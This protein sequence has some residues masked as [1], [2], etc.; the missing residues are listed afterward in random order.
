M[1][2]RLLI[3][4]LAA[5]VVV[6]AL[7]GFL[8]G[9][10][11]PSATS[12]MDMASASPPAAVTADRVTAPGD[13]EIDPRRQQLI[14]VRTAPVKRQALTAT[15][16]TTGTV[17]ADETRQAD[18]NVRLDG[19]IRELFVNYTGQPVRRGERLFTLYS[20]ELLASTGELL[21][22][23]RNREQ[24][25]NAAV[26]D[27]AGYAGQ[28][29]DAARRR[30]AVW[31]LSPEQIAAIE[32]GGRAVDTL[33]ITAPISGIVTEKQAVAGMR[34][35]AGQTLYRIGDLSS[36]WIEADVYE[37]DMAQVRIGQ[38]ATVSLAAYPDRRWT[39][40]AIYIM[41][42]VNEQTRTG[43]VR[44]QFANPAGILKP[45]T[46][47]NVEL[48]ERDRETLTVP[49]DAVLDSGTEQVVFVAE[50][51]GRFTPRRVKVGRRLTDVVE[52][53]DGVKEGEQVATSA[54][55]FL[56]SESQLRAG[57]QNYE[58]AVQGSEPA[59][60]GPALTITFRAQPDP[61][62]TGESVFEVRVTD[63]AGAPVT[64]ADVTVQL[65]MP[66]MPTMSMPAMRNETTLPHAGGGV[67]RGAGQVM[68]A[69]RWEV[70]VTVSRG[71]QRAGS[72]QFAL[73][74]R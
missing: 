37:Q 19:W 71:G 46:F 69:G 28:L 67:Y 8:Y 2:R 5:L 57:L 16:R 34:A 51:E 11:P 61:P 4:L 3:P 49:V 31:G 65:F 44:F 13:I 70:T 42:T 45:G 66:A 48:R 35:M 10:R 29:V 43:R 30:L 9:R 24:A 25:G 12:S 6:L 73:L 14:G 55:F 58:S 21:L 62:R 17:R 64:D 47:A 41:P 38:S 50:G 53:V 27:A 18:V 26:A 39:G 22:A 60:A 56:D 74:A 32:Q 7:A 36:V 59:S 20:P 23:L 40:R 54:A 15:I 52:I 68:T 72:K 1:T 33:T 63:P